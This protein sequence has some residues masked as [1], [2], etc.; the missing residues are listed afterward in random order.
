MFQSPAW[1]EKMAARTNNVVR[2]FN[3]GHWVMVDKADEFNTAVSEW[4]TATR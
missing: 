4:L 3:S 2:E 1:Q